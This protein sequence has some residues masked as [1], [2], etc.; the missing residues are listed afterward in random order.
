M[1]DGT[2][3]V[4][5]AARWRRQQKHDQPSLP[6]LLDTLQR[7]F[8]LDRN[9]RVGARRRTSDDAELLVAWLVARDF[10]V[11]GINL[12]AEARNLVGA[13]Q[14]RAR[15]DAAAVLHSYGHFGVG[16]GGA[17]RV[18]HEAEIGRPLLLAV[19]VV[20]AE[21]GT[22]RPRG[23]RK[24]TGHCEHRA[25]HPSDTPNRELHPVLPGCVAAHP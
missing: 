8:G 9:F 16:N 17:V 10:N 4:P 20:V 24:S 12:L 18:P 14:V 25:H 15:D 13:E 5:R 19:V 3:H 1:T 11:F 21:A 6:S 2:L 7:A 22:A 23:D